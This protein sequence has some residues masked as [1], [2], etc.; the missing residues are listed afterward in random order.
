MTRDNLSFLQ[1]SNTW[2]W[3]CHW[4]T[5]VRSAIMNCNLILPPQFL[6]P[7]FLC[8]YNIWYNPHCSRRADTYGGLWADKD[9]CCIPV[10]ET[11]V[12]Q[13][14]P[15]FYMKK[16]VFACLWNSLVFWLRQSATVLKSLRP[17]S[18]Y[19]S[20]YS[21]A[22]TAHLMIHEVLTSIM[23]EAFLSKYCER[24]TELEALQVNSQPKELTGEE[25]NT[26]KE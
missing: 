21:R 23:L 24:W 16:I 5:A 20:R 6:P 17:W 8:S 7:S 1:K 19:S 12:I 15:W 3:L 26:T 11:R 2:D 13:R 14:I 22:Y 25:W 10:H 4:F 18:P 9:M